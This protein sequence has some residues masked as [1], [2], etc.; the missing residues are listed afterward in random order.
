MLVKEKLLEFMHEKAYNPMLKKE[1]M[2]IFEIDRKQN[3][4]FSSLLNDM[5]EEG[6]I[7]KTRK[8]RYGVPERMGLVVGRLQMN[9]KGYGFVVPDKPG[10]TD[11]F[12]PAN[13]INGAMN[14]DKVVARKDTVYRDFCK[15]TEGEIIRILERANPEVIGVYENNRNFGF[16]IPDDPKIVTDIFIP[17]EEMGEVK[18]GD[19]VVCEIIK[20]PDARRNPEGKIIEIIG[21]RDDVGVDI[22]SIMRKYNLTVDFPKKVEAEIKNISDEVSEKEKAN[23]KDLRDMTT[24]TIDGADA[25]DLDDAVSIEKLSNGNFKLGVHIAD[26]TH[27]VREGTAL[28]KEALERGT[29]VYLVDRVVPMLPR[30]LSNGICS[31]NP[32][33][34]RLTLSVFMEINKKGEVINHEIA[35]SVINVKERM[36]YEDIS[37]ILEKDDQN[38]KDKYSHLLNEFKMMEELC[39]ILKKHRENRG[40]IDF[41]FPETKVILDKDGK[42]VDII[43]YERRIANRIIEEFMLICNETIAEHFYWQDVPFVYRVHEDPSLEKLEEFNEFIYNFGYHLK[44]LNTGIHPKALQDLLEKVK[45]AKEERLINT[46]MLRSLKKARY[47]DKGLGHFG[48]AAEH[49]CHFTAPIRRYPDLEIHRIIKEA[50]NGKLDNER[51]SRLREIVPGVAEQSSIRE[52]VAD[53]AERETTDLKKVEYMADRIG[54]EYEGIISGLTSFGIFVELDNTIEGLIPLSYLYDD[55]YIYDSER[56]ILTGE[57]RK[58]TYRIGDAIKV[59]VNRVNIAQKEIDFMI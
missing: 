18:E 43:K 16:V 13:L 58:K 41:D 47:A 9:Q 56:H 8:K 51:I 46:L 22:L 48:L 12:I 32:K 38:L 59:K 55:Y 30:K 17:K 3:R 50:I 20:W 42:P 23:R 4:L 45:G 21:H 19:K 5:V 2:D 1:L 54:E 33:V 44:G 25:K 6:L 52:R 10:I 53:E 36:I 34:D 37:D 40:A 39:L 26:V 7:I 27:Y 28:D 14:N 49:Y 29:S 15:K 57:M 24:I 11:V 35:E 31:L